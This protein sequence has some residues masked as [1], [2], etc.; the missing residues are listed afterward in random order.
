MKRHRY[1]KKIITKLP[2]YYASQLITEEGLK[3][4]ESK[5]GDRNKGQS[6]YNSQEKWSEEM[7]NK[8]IRKE[9]DIYIHTYRVYLGSIFSFIHVS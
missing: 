8:K 2:A 9:N 6:D 5:C 1:I 4:L 7:E 3:E